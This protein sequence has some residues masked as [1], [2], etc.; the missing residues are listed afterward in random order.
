MTTVF[1]CVF[2][3]AW[4]SLLCVMIAGPFCG[5]RFLILP[6]DSDNKLYTHLSSIARLRC[7]ISRAQLSN[8]TSQQSGVFALIFSCVY[9]FVDDVFL[10]RC[11]GCISA[12][13]A[14]R[15]CCVH[16]WCYET[17]ADL[18]R[19][20]VNSSKFVSSSLYLCLKSSYIQI[21]KQSANQLQLVNIIIIYYCVYFWYK[22]G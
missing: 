5:K 10:L 8:S 13:S 20:T 1:R 17:F 16:E 19:S 9:V 4:W 14:S 3:I 22:Y 6:N 2:D 7:Q 21:Q 18:F 11:G 12:W 15:M